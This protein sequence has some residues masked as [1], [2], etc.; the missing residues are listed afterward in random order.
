[1][2]PEP[3]RK[4]SALINGYSTFKLVW[5]CFFLTETGA[6]QNL[7]AA[8]TCKYFALANMTPNQFTIGT[9]ISK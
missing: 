6:K 2:L 7:E 8:N 3:C 9:N 5:G 1:M 4:L